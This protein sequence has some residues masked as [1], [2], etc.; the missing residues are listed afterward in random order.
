VSSFTQA[1]GVEA[2]SFAILKPFLEEHTNGRYVVTGKGPLARAYQQQCGDILLNDKEGKLFA[3]ELKAERRHTGNLFLETWS[4]RNLDCI[5]SHTSLGSNPGWMVH[6]RASLLFY[7]F[8]DRDAL[9]ILPFFKLK[10]WAFG[11]DGKPGN[12]YRF[13]E[14][15]QGKYEQLNDTHGR[16]VPL[17]ELK[18]LGLVKVFHPRQAE[19]WP[20]QAA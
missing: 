15:P 10:Q 5:S 17:V 3:V 16:L 2:E 11:S 8:L 4:N 14:R 19:M 12:I 9:Y 7:H 6:L 13:P 18:A 1:Q 20:E